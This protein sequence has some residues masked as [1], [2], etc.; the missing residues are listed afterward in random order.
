MPAQRRRRRDVDPEE[1]RCTCSSD[2]QDGPCK[3]CAAKM[4]GTD[5]KVRRGAERL[6]CATGISVSRAELILVGILESEGWL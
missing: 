5:A 2:P 1:P 3:V 4:D 6:A